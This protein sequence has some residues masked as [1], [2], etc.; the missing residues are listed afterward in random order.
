MSN[1]Q[2]HS[3]WMP[4]TKTLDNCRL[5]TNQQYDRKVG[6]RSGSLPVPE[7]TVVE[8]GLME[9]AKSEA[10]LDKEFPCLVHEVVQS[11]P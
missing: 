6:Q 1:H 2:L 5:Y 8:G 4:K 11:E 7:S 3:T 9:P 10:D